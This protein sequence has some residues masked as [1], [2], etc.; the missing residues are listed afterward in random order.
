MFFR[1]A[2]FS[3]M[4]T[5]IEGTIRTGALEAITIVERKSSA[6]PFAIFP[7]MLAVAGRMMISS[8]RSARAT[9]PICASSRRAKA[10]V[11]TGFPESVWNVSGVMN[12]WAWRVMTT[13][14]PASAFTRSLTNS[15][16]L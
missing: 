4:F 12:S 14:T 3:H 6:I 10:S 8:A 16:A 7:M 9:C 13:W 1:T 15:A 5:F 11:M 2:A